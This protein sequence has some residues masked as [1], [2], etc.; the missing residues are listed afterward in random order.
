MKHV[1]ILVL[2]L[3]AAGCKPL[4]SYPIDSVWYQPPAGAELVLNKPLEFPPR[5][6]SLRFQDGNIVGG[7]ADFE[8]NCVL[9]LKTLRD[10]PQR[11]EPDTFTMTKVRSGSSTQ[12]AA[13]PSAPHFVKVDQGGDTGS[14]RYY[15]KTEMFLHSDKQPDVFLLTCQHAWDTGSSFQYERS[16]SLAEMRQ[17][18]GSYFSFKLPG[19]GI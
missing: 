13:L 1:L 10:E 7:V 6:V 18:L 19:V 9:Q 16:P 12:R 11:I 14:I 17:A 15:Y 2:A 5:T 8:P 4:S 3:A